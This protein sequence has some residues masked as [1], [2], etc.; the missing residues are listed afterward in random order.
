MQQVILGSWL[1]VDNYKFSH[2]RIE[3]SELIT[4]KAKEIIDIA[5]IYCYK[6]I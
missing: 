4:A 3:C 1:D 5:Q 6:I 2:K